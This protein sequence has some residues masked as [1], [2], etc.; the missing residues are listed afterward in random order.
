MSKYKYDF[1]QEFGSQHLSAAVDL[2]DDLGYEESHLDGM[3]HE[4]MRDLLYYAA[5][6]YFRAQSRFTWSKIDG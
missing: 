5:R 3:S 6:V 4:D 2:V 1:S